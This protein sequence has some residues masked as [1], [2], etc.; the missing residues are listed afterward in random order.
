MQ[1][2]HGGEP[3]VEGLIVRREVAGHRADA[4][5]AGESSTAGQ[6]AGDGPVGRA[7]EE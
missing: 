1:E 6:E 2:Y 3:Q 5:G 7:A 4:A